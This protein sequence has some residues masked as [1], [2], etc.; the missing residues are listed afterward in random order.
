MSEESED[1]SLPCIAISSQ[2]L[3]FLR[4][5]HLKQI[6]HILQSPNYRL[7]AVV[8]HSGQGPHSGHY[9]AHVRSGNNKWHCMNDS[10]VS[11]V[12]TSIA[13]NQRN[14]YLL[15]YERINRLGDA[16]GRTEVS[17]GQSKDVAQ[18][19]DAASSVTG[20]NG[21]RKERD[22]ESTSF[23]QQR[24][25]LQNQSSHQSFGKS[26]SPNRKIQPSAMSGPASPLRQH[27]NH[28]S[29]GQTSPTS[30]KPKKTQL[31]LFTQTGPVLKNPQFNR[32]HAGIPTPAF[33][34][35]ANNRK[36]RRKSLHANMNP[37]PRN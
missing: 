31:G 10:S 24:I 15:F 8:C 28:F 29:Q 9:F 35:T 18:T 3:A 21:K 7:Y 33:F 22:E 20:T 1:V 37:R 26:D 30:P 6:L 2:I 32:G 23:P 27:T 25:K 11:E 5:P 16:V 34:S 19:V 17:G 36:P 13:C 12:Q 14:A 4:Y